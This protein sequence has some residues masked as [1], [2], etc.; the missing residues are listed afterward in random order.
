MPAWMELVYTVDS[1]STVV[2]HAGSNPAA[3]TN[4]KTKILQKELLCMRIVKYKTKLT[5]DGKATLEKERSVNCP[6]ME[7]KMTSPRRN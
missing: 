3:G 4:I 5:A 7:R 2:R 1:K 6:D